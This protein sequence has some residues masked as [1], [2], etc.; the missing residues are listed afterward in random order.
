MT[1]GKT[2]DKLRKIIM[3]NLVEKLMIGKDMLTWESWNK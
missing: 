3:H 2:N 1:L